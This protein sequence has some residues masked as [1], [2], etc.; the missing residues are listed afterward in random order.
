MIYQSNT[1]A[2]YIFLDFCLPSCVTSSFMSKSLTFLEFWGEGASHR[3][4]NFCAT[5]LSKRENN[6]LYYNY[7]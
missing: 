2:R 4:Y 5:P 6:R 7:D 3:L 1:F